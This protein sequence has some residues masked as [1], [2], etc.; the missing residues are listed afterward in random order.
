MTDYSEGT[1]FIVKYNESGSAIW[2]RTCEGGG[3]G[4]RVT[5][6]A[7]GNVYVGGEFLYS[8][9]IFGNDTVSN[10]IISD[11]V[12]DVFTVK[13]DPSGNVM[14][15]TGPVGG[16]NCY[17]GGISAD[18]NGNIYATGTFKESTITFGSTTLRNA[19]TENIFVVKYDSAGNVLWAGSAGGNNS[20]EGSD[21]CA[22]PPGE[23]FLAG[24]F[25][26][27]VIN[28]GSTTLANTS[29]NDIF[30]A[31]I[32]ICYLPPPPTN[33]TAPA[34]QSVCFNNSATLSASGAGVLSWYDGYGNLLQTGDSY[35]TLPLVYNTTF[36]VQDSTCGSSA[37]TA[38]TAMVDSQLNAFII[39]LAN[40]TLTTG[41][42]ATYQW[43]LNGSP[44]HAATYQYYMATANGNYQ[45]A[46]S[47]SI[48]CTDTS[49]VYSITTAGIP[50]VKQAGD[51][52]VYPNPTAGEIYF[53]GIQ[54]GNA[55]E[56]YNV[57]GELIYSS[58]ANGNDYKIE[59]SGKDSGIYFYRVTGTANVT[60]QGKIVLQ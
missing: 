58:V 23:A 38:I 1:F 57:L 37:Q 32:G 2:A 26:S 52:R 60:Q 20:D 30:L 46:V 56:V 29:S 49:D 17:Y 40:D 45:V 42:Y 43:L 9:V 44:I 14:W 16:A 21:I 54:T 8:S 7:R 22:G 50:A 53:D 41:T 47:D 33:I 11:D 15:A 6:D 12:F 10:N 3:F 31:K 5:T 13:Y 48:G 34:A 55:I 25:S 4:E 28:F 36:Y 27:P 24:D 59:L 35:T 18:A 51:I 19:G 39:P